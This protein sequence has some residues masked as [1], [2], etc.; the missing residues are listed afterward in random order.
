VAGIAMTDLAQKAEFG[1]DDTDIFVN[2]PIGMVSGGQACETQNPAGFHL[3]VFTSD[4]P[5]G[6]EILQALVAAGF[7]NPNNE[8]QSGPNDNFNLK[9]GCASDAIVGQIAG[10]V[11]PKAGKPL[12]RMHAFEASD[13]DIFVNLP[14]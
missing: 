10:I 9:W 1:G 2:L 5:R 8:V 6:Q 14:F 3:V 12:E 7:S 4:E 11:E 13:P